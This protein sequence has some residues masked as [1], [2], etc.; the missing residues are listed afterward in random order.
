MIASTLALIER[1]S[2][3]IQELR[4][5]QRHLCGRNEGLSDCVQCQSESSI[6]YQE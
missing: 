6:G 3:A 4:D 1:T 2:K 5:R